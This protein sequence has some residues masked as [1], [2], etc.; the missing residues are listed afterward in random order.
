MEAMDLNQ[1]ALIW[2]VLS[3]VF[4]VLE[5][6]LIPGIGFLFAGFAAITVGGLVNF[7]V[8]SSE[9][10]FAQFA[11]FFG[12]LFA[13]A[14]I[15]WYPIKAFRNKNKGDDFQNIIGDSAIVSGNELTKNKNGKV[16]W[17]GTTMKARL[18]ADDAKDKVKKD[19]EVFVVAINGNTLT[20]TSDINNTKTD[21]GEE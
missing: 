13:W 19:D 3:A 21:K 6:S 18:Y 2:L 5:V 20:V 8:V 10:Y 1:A 14:A 15:L 11:Y 7:G 9:A 17:S 4:F 12:L 16:K